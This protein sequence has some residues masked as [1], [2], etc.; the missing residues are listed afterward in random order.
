MSDNS[1]ESES[2]CFNYI[3]INN[4]KII[5]AFMRTTFSLNIYC[6]LF[7]FIFVVLF[8]F[9]VL[10][11]NTNSLLLNFLFFQFLF[12]IVFVYLLF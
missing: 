7:I 9:I 12:V 11:F 5:M 3:I 4:K 10:Y 8:M 2:D 1:S 6:I